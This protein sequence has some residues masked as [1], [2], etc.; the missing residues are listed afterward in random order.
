[1][2][3]ISLETALRHLR[4]VVGEMT[5]AAQ[6]P[7]ATEVATKLKQAEAI[8]LDYVQPQPDPA[9]AVD[10]APGAVQAA[11]SIVLSDLWEHRAG[12]DTDDVFL[13]HAAKA[14]L[15]KYRKPSLA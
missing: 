15:Q 10:T 9:W 6:H 8:V 7:Q 2:A 5:D 11:V 12:S 14:L 4:L 3:L 13:S 1:M